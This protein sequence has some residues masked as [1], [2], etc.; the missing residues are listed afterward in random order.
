MTI[1]IKSQNFTI[2]TNNVEP[3]LE[4]LKT[5]YPE[6]VQVLD[7][8]EPASNLQFA[9]FIL[10][11]HIKIQVDSSI[12]TISNPSDYTT[13]VENE[14]PIKTLTCLSKYMSDDSYII[15]EIDGEEVKFTKDKKDVTKTKDTSYP[16]RED[17]LPNTVPQLTVEPTVEEIIEEPSKKR[18]RNKRVSINSNGEVR[19]E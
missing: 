4:E 10:G 5:I 13:K 12:F 17:L 7:Y 14:D 11:Y 9:L 8:D 15:V 3:T 16:S 19:N 1:K 6:I 2:A 18:S